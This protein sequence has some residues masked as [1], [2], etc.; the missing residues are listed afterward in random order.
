MIISFSLNL[1]SEISCPKK[2]ISKVPFRY[3][4]LNG[5]VIAEI[6]EEDMAENRII[7]TAAQKGSSATHVA[8]VISATPGQRVPMYSNASSSFLIFSAWNNET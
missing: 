6:E 5:I 8:K 2:L 1:Y 3:L 4:S 7:V